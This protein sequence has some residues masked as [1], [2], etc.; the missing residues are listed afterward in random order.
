MSDA[1]VPDTGDGRLG[2]LPA[3]WHLGSPASFFPGAMRWFGSC[4]MRRTMMLRI[5]VVAAAA[6]SIVM[7]LEGHVDREGGALLERECGSWLVAGAAVILDMTAIRFVDRAGIA[8]LGRL[9]RAGVEIRCSGV[10]A[11]VLE[12]E[13][14][15]IVS[16]TS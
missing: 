14:V 7:R 5:T 16:V 13:D 4:V 6:K 2:R 10:V 8:A 11:C 9:A 1:T 15:P 12:S 3:R